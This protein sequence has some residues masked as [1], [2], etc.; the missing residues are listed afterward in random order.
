MG[1][2]ADALRSIGEAVAIRR[3][4]ADANP[5]AFLPSLAISFGAW[6]RVLREDEPQLAAEKFGEG[7]QIIAPFVT[8]LPQAH[9]RV[10]AMLA[11]DYRG[12]CEAAGIDMDESVVPALETIA[13]FI[14]EG[15]GEGES[16]PEKATGAGE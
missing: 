16:P 9:L 7:L 1:Q 5:D 8:A 2:R 12:A 14:N 13:A 10:A 3:K 6:G 11:Q 4:L 15:A